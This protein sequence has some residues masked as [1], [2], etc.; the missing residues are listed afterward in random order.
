MLE[1]AHKNLFKVGFYIR[2]ILALQHARLTADNARQ[3]MREA[4]RGIDERTLETLLERLGYYNRLSAAS[5]IPAAS[6]TL[7]D[8]HGRGSK[9]QILDFRH[10]FQAFP[11]HLRFDYQLGDIR[12]LPAVPTFL[13][14]RPLVADNHNAI[15]LKINEV[16]H[17]YWRRDPYRFAEKR[18]SA[19]W[20]GA[21]HQPHRQRALSALLAARLVDAGDVRPAAEGTPAH[22]PFQA[23][24]AQMR[25]KFIISLEG[26]DVAT[27]LKWIMRSNSLC[28][29]PR[30]RCESWFMEGHLRP[31]EHYVELPREPE[32]IDAVI[33]HYARH[34]EEAHAIIRNAN[35][36]AAQF[37]APAREALLQR[38]V[39]L[40]YFVL[41]GQLDVDRS[42]PE[43]VRH[44]L[45][46]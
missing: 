14:S 41:S 13:K 20:R 28:L 29:M 4:L 46:G 23:P 42:L 30:P 12:A 9:T 6:A 11:S 36:F 33:E 1:Q 5:D 17:Y 25:H 39:A 31:G 15:L 44:A 24:R 38:L 40:K 45:S 27:N 18:N 7:P 26:N 37:Y 22:Q 16:R 8:L 35:A 3:Q 43:P 21:C 34:D 32:A 19:V 2:R 10:V